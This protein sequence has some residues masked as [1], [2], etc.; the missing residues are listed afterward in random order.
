MPDHFE[1][2]SMNCVDG[3]TPAEDLFAEL[4]YETFGLENAQYL[5]NEFPFQDI[6]G[7]S[8]YI[9]YALQTRLQRYAIEIDGEQVHNPALISLDKYQDDLMRRNSLTYQRW[10]V[11]IWTYRQLANQREQV[12]SELRQFLGQDPHFET[13]EDYL[14]CQ[15]GK[16]LELR[17]HQKECLNNLEAWREEKGSMALVADAQGTGKTTVA[18]LDAKRMGLRTLFIAHRLE[19]LDQAVERFRELWP[20]ARTEKITDYEEQ[21]A[22]EVVVASIQRIFQNLDQ[23]SPNQ[24]DYMI[25]D[26]AHHAAADTYRKVISYFHPLF[27]L[28]LTATP[29]R[30]DQES[31]MEIFKHEAHR[32]DLKT[33]V[34]IGELVPI[35]CVRVKTNID[36]S[37]VHFNGIKY[38]IQDLD[39]KVHLPERNQLIV[40]TYLTHVSGEKTVVF[41]ASV[42]HARE[43]AEL[44]TEWGVPARAV[45]G[46]MKKED[47]QEVLQAYE[48]DNI[49]ILCACDI[50]NEGWDSP[51]TSVLFMARPTLSRVIYLQQLGRGTR[52]APGK[53]ALLVF[54]FVDETNRLNHA[55]SLH[56]LL[57][58]K[59]YRP[60]ALMLAPDEQMAEEHA[61]Y[62][63]GEKPELFLPHNVY[64]TDYEVIDIFDWQEEIKDM[65][66]AHQLAIELYVDDKTVRQWI[67]SNRISPGPDLEMKMG[68]INYRYFY[69]QRVDEIRSK[70]G[71]KKRTAATLK[72]DFL[73]FVRSGDMS[74]SYKPVLLKGMLGL[75]D[76]KGEV[77]LGK[78]TSYFRDFYQSRAD[79]GHPVEVPKS[80]LNRI[81]ELNDFELTRL[82]LTMPFEKFER[83]SFMEHKRDLN[84]VAFNARLW[85]ALKVEEKQMLMKICD[86]QVE[87]YYERRF[88]R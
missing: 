37:R 75:A 58:Q 53:Q 85:K 39:E 66:S 10:Q 42:D 16:V 81:G 63:L 76:D 50:L 64:A 88:G 82:M 74:M 6:Y 4:F 1:N 13:G 20:Q 71:I 84:N 70:L 30:H 55:V 18:V 17:Q 67:D 28:G 72:E 49:K 36:F 2:N 48:N 61:A 8:R 45:D 35:R 14:P 34:E 40:D 22:A 43:L 9:D 5:M 19:L 15:K 46:R 24:F 41:C 7:N 38:N 65:I 86:E 12:K 51:K 73:S 77:D 21:P 56:R 68:Q 87:R 59:E 79:Q 25:I 78:L 32:L 80:I 83:K 27:L 23:F 57:K 29:E 31:I 47:R 69:K 52:T 62:L 3:A 60:G 54:D 11:Y 44:F 33:A 26:E